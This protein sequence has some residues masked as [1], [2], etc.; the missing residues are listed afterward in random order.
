MSLRPVRAAQKKP[1]GSSH[2]IVGIKKAPKK[3]EVVNQA[4]NNVVNEES[5]D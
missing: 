5:D 2:N 3:Q 1:T 4:D